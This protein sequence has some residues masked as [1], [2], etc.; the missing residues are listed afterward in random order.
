MR[1]RPLKGLLA[2]MWEFPCTPIGGDLEEKG[3]KCDEAKEE[4]ARVILKNKSTKDGKTATVVRG[5]RDDNVKVRLMLSI[6][7]GEA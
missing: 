4:K 6:F 1:Q 2:G 5:K 3:S 7:V